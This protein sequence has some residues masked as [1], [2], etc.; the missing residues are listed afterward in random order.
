MVGVFLTMQVA[1]L[2]VS[3]RIGRSLSPRAVRKRYHWV[4]L[5]Q[6]VL[7]GMLVC[8]L[9]S[10]G[11]PEWQ[12]ILLLCGIMVSM[13]S[14]IWKVT[15][16]QTEDD[17]QRNYADD[18]GHCG[19]CEYDLTGNVSGIC[20]ECGWV[21]PKTP[22]R[23]QSPDWARWWQKWEIEYLEN[24]PRSLRTVRL[25]AAVFGAIAIGLLVWLG[26][27]GSGSRWFSLLL[28]LP[29]WLIAG[30][31][32]ILSVRV[33]A[34]GRKQGDQPAGETQ[35]RGQEQGGPQGPKCR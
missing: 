2:I 19:R 30:H 21:I 1:G 6:T 5:N 34:Y 13:V 29:A 3:R 9:L 14:L 11:L 25:S 4:V 15:R 22:M 24:W 18:T 8:A 16:R 23:M 32:L 7:L 33:A 31:M 28:T 27:Y 10:Q 17:A 35:E 20:P 12:M 26:G